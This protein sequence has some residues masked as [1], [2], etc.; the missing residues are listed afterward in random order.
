MSESCEMRVRISLLW[1][2]SSFW[3]SLPSKKK[4][5][6]PSDSVALG[7]LS[8]IEEL[9]RQFFISW[10][11][12]SQAEVTHHRM[13]F[14]HPAIDVELSSSKSMNRKTY[15]F[16]WSKET[17]GCLAIHGTDPLQRTRHRCLLDIYRSLHSYSWNC[18]ERPAT[19]E[20]LSLGELNKI[21]QIII[22]L[23][24]NANRKYLACRPL[25]HSLECLYQVG[26]YYESCPLE[27]RNLFGIYQYVIL[28]RRLGFWQF[29]L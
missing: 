20:Y 7:S 16:P 9:R 19:D 29:A 18:Q 26:V 23:K 5:A 27:R 17:Q 15:A 1:S 21:E 14:P 22:N 11:W 4:Y 28:N 25:L 2:C 24:K 3:E 6:I 8:I 10:Y 13:L 12:T